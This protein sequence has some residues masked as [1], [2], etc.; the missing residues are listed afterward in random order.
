MRDGSA[1]PRLSVAASV[2]NIAYSPVGKRSIVR[3]LTKALEPASVSTNDLLNHRQQILDP[4]PSSTRFQMLSSKILIPTQGQASVAAPQPR[5]ARCTATGP[6][7]LEQRTPQKINEALASS[8]SLH[9]PFPLK[10][11]LT[12]ALV[13]REPSLSPTHSLFFCTQSR[14]VSLS[15]SPGTQP[16]IEAWSHRDLLKTSCHRISSHCV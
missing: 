8:S 2:S 5:R 9:G 12:L 1:R 15:R 4:Q 11:P 3:T 13:A 7:N 10:L 6:S 14:P 16:R